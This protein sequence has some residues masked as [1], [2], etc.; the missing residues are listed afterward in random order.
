[1]L[2]CLPCSF[3]DIEVFD[4]PSYSF[5]DNNVTGNGGGGVN[6]RKTS[7][8]ITIIFKATTKIFSVEAVIMSTIMK[9]VG[10]FSLFFVSS[11]TV[12]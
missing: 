1:M 12:R 9:R 3:P 4:C 5:I 7:E 6:K 8:A 11:V 2:E 10:T